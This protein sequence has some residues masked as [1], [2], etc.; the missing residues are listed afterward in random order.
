MLNYQRVAFLVLNVLWKQ[1]S[2]PVCWMIL[3]AG[4]LA[5]YVMGASK[6]NTIEMSRKSDEISQAWANYPGDGG[7][8]SHGGSPNSSILRGFSIT[9]HP[10]LGY[11]IFGKFH[12]HI[13]LFR[14]FLSSM[15]CKPIYTPNDLPATYLLRFQASKFWGT[16]DCFVGKHD[17]GNKNNLWK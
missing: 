16:H 6:S 5:S 11:P 8:L 7:F 15:V 10:F 9:N 2:E 4:D 1:N 17:T 13:I 12:I 3:Q 14:T